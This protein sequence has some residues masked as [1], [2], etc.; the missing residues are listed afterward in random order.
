MPRKPKSPS[1]EESLKSVI[2]DVAKLKK[3]VAQL[4]AARAQK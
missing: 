2:A 3:A 4:Q 1:V